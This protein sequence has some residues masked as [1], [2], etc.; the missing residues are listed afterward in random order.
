MRQAGRARL[1]SLACAVESLKILSGRYCQKE[2][3]GRTRAALDGRD[4]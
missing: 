4:I 2:A 3:T 1:R